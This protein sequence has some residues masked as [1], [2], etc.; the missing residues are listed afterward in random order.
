M[1]QNNIIKSI[2]EIKRCKGNKYFL[3]KYAVNTLYACF[4]TFI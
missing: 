2:T 1:V 3:K 4:N